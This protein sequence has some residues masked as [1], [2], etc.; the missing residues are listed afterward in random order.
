MIRNKVEKTTF[1]YYDSGGFHCAEAIA[2]TIIELYA[3]NPDAAPIKT[4]SGFMG[5]IGSTQ[6]G[7]CGALTGAI[8]AI[9]YLYGRTEPGKDIQ[10]ARELAA[11]FTGRFVE[12]FGSANCGV[13]LEK[14][15][16]Q[17]NKLKCKKLTATAAGLLSELL[18]EINHETQF[19]NGQ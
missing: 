8:I 15:G 11:E 18:G 14:F 13:L 16:K 17:H 6:T 4:A 5:G 7:T 2:K 12:E 10:H 3:E 9:G 1:D 19:S